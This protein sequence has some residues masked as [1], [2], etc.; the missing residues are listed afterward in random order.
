MISICSISIYNT[1][2]CFRGVIQPI[3]VTGIFRPFLIV[4][5]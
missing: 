4:R 5:D 2:F 1:C 3:V